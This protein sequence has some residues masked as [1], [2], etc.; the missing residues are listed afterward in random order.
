[1]DGW[2]S[3]RADGWLEGGMNRWSGVN[4]FEQGQMIDT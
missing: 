4:F 3:G 1:M 2:V